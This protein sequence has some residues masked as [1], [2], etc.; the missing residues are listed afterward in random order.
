M[1]PGMPTACGIVS[2]KPI[3]MLPGSPSAC[4]LAFE[5]FVVPALYRMMNVRVLERK[6]A[7]KK[8]ILQSR[9]PSEIGVRSYVRVRWDNGK[10]YPVRISGSSILS[11]LVKANALLLVPENLEGYEA[12]E[13]VEVRLI[14]DLTEVFE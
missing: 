13:E 11:S 5:T 4:L 6:G 14:R 8:G 2:G 1:K 10:V 3:F 9:V 12:G 7:I